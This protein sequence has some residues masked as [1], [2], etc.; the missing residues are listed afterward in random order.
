MRCRHYVTCTAWCAHACRT[1]TPTPSLTP[2]RA[3]PEC[4]WHRTPR[5]HTPHPPS[6]QWPPISTASRRASLGPVSVAAR[7]SACSPAGGS[8]PGG[9]HSRTS[10]REGWAWGG[11]VPGGSGARWWVRKGPAEC[12]RCNEVVQ[13]AIVRTWKMRLDHRVRA[14]DGCGF[15]RSCGVVTVCERVSSCE[16]SCPVH[17]A[18]RSTPPVLTCDCRCRNLRQ[19]RQAGNQPRHDSLASTS[20]VHNMNECLIRSLRPTIKA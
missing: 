2:H 7:C 14:A 18:A 4:M 10:R 12:E 5:P 1:A 3:S 8:T 16:A 9:Q 17:S 6:L 13:A 20:P 19:P 11:G 15:R